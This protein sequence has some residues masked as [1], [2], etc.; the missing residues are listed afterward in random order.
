M[1]MKLT[2]GQ[3]NEFIHFLNDLKDQMPIL[4]SLQS[5]LPKTTLEL[6]R[7]IHERGVSVQ[8][9]ES[10]ASYLQKL[11][12]KFQFQNQSPFDENTSHIIGR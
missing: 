1:K 11:L 2:A 12:S 6:L 4:E 5:E 7:S 3:S 10:M 9:A 8:E